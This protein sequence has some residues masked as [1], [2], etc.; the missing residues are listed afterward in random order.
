MAEFRSCPRFAMVFFLLVI[1]LISISPPF[2]DPTAINFQ[3]KPGSLR[4]HPS[5]RMTWGATI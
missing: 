2:H 3:A 1:S 5:A 4:Q